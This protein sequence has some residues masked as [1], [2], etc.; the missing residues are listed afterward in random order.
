MSAQIDDRS[1]SLG[2]SFTVA[3]I[4][5]I[6]LALSFVAYYYRRKFEQLKDLLYVEYNNFS[7]EQPRHFDNPVYASMPSNN[8]KLLNNLNNS[9][10]INSPKNTNLI[11]SKLFNDF[12]YEKSDSS[13]VYEVPNNNL[14]VE[15][16]EDKCKSNNFY[17][18]I[19]EVD[20]QNISNSKSLN[21][22]GG[23]FNCYSIDA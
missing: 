16:D 10:N 11:K 18:T 15:V 5:I 4:F 12:D 22:N 2:V 3:I 21:V 7:S 17:H 8:T 6:I 19:D 20:I 1:S 14:Y 13:N 23:M 9:V